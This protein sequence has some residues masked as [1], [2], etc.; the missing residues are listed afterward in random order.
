[1]GLSGARRRGAPGR[2]PVGME[3]HGKTYAVYGTL[4]TP[5]EK[6]DVREPWGSRGKQWE[7]VRS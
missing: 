1:M 2:K 7:W 6:A 3:A 5:G 4:G